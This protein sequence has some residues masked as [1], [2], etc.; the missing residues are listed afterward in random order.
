MLGILK[1]TQDNPKSV[2]SKV[3]LQNF[4]QQS[5]INWDLS[6]PKLD[7]A[8]YQKYNLTQDEIDFIESNVSAMQ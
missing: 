2:W 3:P 7:A 4:T 8:L 6:I 1:V 5:E